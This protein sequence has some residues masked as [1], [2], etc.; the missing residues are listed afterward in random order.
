MYFVILRHNFWKTTKK[1][2]TMLGY[3]SG[4][5][6]LRSIVWHLQKNSAK[7]IVWCTHSFSAI[8]NRPHGC[9]MY[10]PRHTRKPWNCRRNTACRLLLYTLKNPYYQINNPK[11][12]I[13][14]EWVPLIHSLYW[15][16]E[17]SVLWHTQNKVCLATPQDNRS[18]IE[19]WN[20]LELK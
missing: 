20:T 16:C 15:K 9:D 11:F 18:Q 6:C 17:L 2:N 19:T 13:L 4:F 14:L 12:V 1:R 10:C 8:R 5:H 3:C 7:S